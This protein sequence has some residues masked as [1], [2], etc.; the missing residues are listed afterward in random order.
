METINRN[1]TFEIKDL[2]TPVSEIIARCEPEGRIISVQV[3]YAVNGGYRITIEQGPSIPLNFKD[4]NTIMPIK[5]AIPSMIVKKPLRRSNSQRLDE[6][7]RVTFL[8]DSKNDIFTCIEYFLKYGEMEYL[9]LTEPNHHNIRR[10]FV[11][12]Y[13][14]GA[15]QTAI[16]HSSPQLQCQLAK[17]RLAKKEDEDQLIQHLKCGKNIHKITI[18][19]HHA[20]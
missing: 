7:T 9:T 4:S 1:T 14:I 12:Y 18:K 11:S 8:S 2:S 19:D 17:K 10:G 6:D 16:K 3:D 15:A 20:C 13:D 5:P